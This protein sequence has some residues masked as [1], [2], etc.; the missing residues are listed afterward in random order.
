M[1]QSHFGATQIPMGAAAPGMAGAGAGARTWAAI[2]Q[3]DKLGFAFICS[4]FWLLFELGR[5]YTPPGLPL[6]LTAVLFFEWIGKQDKQLGRF[7]YLWLVLIVVIGSG[8]AFATNNFASYF[9]ARLMGTL[10]IGV[11][12]PLQGLITSLRRVRWWIYTFIGIAFYVGAWA[13]THGGFGP[14][15]ADGQDENYVA[16]LMGMGMAMAYFTFFTDKR[17]WFRLALGVAMFA[18]I[19]A[20]AL[21]QNPSRGGFLG[22]IAVVGYCIWR[23]PRKMVGLSIVGVGVVMLLAVAG[24]SFWK[25][26]DTTTDYQDGTGDMRLELWKAGMRM[27]TKNPVLGVGSGN[28]RWEVGNYQSEE[29]FQKFGRSLGGAVIAHSMH[30]EMLA[31]LGT[32]GAICMI[33]LTWNAWVGLGK[34]RP[35]RPGPGEAPVHPDLVHLGCFADALRAAILAVLVNGTFLS[36]FYYSHLWVCIAVG[37]ALP[38]V[39]KRILAREAMASGAQPG[40]APAMPMAPALAGQ[41]RRMRGLPPRGRRG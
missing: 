36:L 29:Q 10:F 27:Y 7:W 16:C 3:G 17:L 1:R 28:F 14:A 6:L 32:A 22:L 8:V 15:A 9:S 25:E 4:L 38:Y 35:K 26:I 33:L 2:R 34:I 41:P 40:F 24:D 5:P 21:A 13:A 12:L 19:A 30:V 39:H 31:E 18:F 37:T 23:S 20:M 11:L